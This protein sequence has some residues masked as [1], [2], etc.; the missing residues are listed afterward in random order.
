MILYVTFFA[1]IED[2]LAPFKLAF[3]PLG[4]RVFKGKKELRKLVT[5]IIVKTYG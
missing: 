1:H 4:H 2:R 5:R 3:Q